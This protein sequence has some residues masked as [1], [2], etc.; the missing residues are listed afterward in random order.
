[1]TINEEAKQIHAEVAALKPG[2]GRK[3]TT[4]LRDRVLVWMERAR[5]FWRAA[6]PEPRAAGIA[7]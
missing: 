1:M 3:Y 2:R 7:L 4:F 5:V 6:G